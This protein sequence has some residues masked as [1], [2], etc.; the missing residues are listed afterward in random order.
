MAIS[1]GLAANPLDSLQNLVQKSTGKQKVDLLIILGSRV[2]PV[3]VDKATQYAK[4]ALETAKQI[5]YK[6]GEAKSN[7]NIGIC[8]SEKGLYTQGINYLLESNRIFNELNDKSGIV[9]TLSRIGNFYNML[10]NGSKAISYTYSTIN[11]ITEI[12]ID[13][14]INNYKSSNQTVK[15][16]L[17]KALNLVGNALN[18][19]GLVLAT[20]NDSKNA[21]E[22]FKSALNIYNTI[23]NDELKIALTSNI[24][25]AYSSWN[26]T[27]EALKYYAQALKMADDMNHKV[28]QASISLDIAYLY[29]K[30]GN[31]DEALKYYFKAIAINNQ[32]GRTSGLSSIYISIGL[33]YQKKGNHAEAI[34]YLQKALNIAQ[35]ENNTYDYANVSH[36]LSESYADIGDYKSAYLYLHKYLL[37]EDSLKTFENNRIMNSLMIKYNAEKSE[38]ELA[39]SQ[40]ELAQKNSFII[41]IV[42]ILIFLLI[43]TIILFKSYSI[44]KKNNTQLNIINEE[45]NKSR[46]EL[47]DLNSTK[48]KFFSI[49]AHDM[50]NPLSSFKLIADLISNNLKD[51]NEDEL[52]YYINEM[53]N[54]AINLNSLL[55]NLLTWSRSQRGLITNNPENQNI[56][57]IVK[58]TMD[59]LKLQAGNKKI[60]LVNNVDSKLECYIDSN[61][62]STVIRNLISNSIKFTKENGTITVNAEITEDNN[63]ATIS[64][65]DNGVGMSEDKIKKL[66]SISENVSTPGTNKEKGTGL[67]LILC[68][69][70]VGLNNG[71]IWAESQIDVGSKFKISLPIA[72]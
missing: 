6:K 43:T 16:S 34:E 28:Y 22:L 70:F 24:G 33:I 15:D 64:I 14:L 69:E 10:G 8:L 38:K 42:V 63:M 37:I 12:K 36:F 21:I 62:I 55:D 61:M 18:D 1:C 23:S 4:Q 44:K 25:L 41:L 32:V 58:N 27:A 51:F 5:G 29:D 45:I 17:A 47:K 13:K 50:K 9:F 52:R 65:E 31:Q 71:K 54:S 11:A 57:Y 35:S 46:E 67:G 48:D 60:S 66:F 3:D 40:N 20:N 49:V 26:R 68:K 30:A 59:I 53:L 7:A 2:A 39:K 19:A 72:K 56:Q